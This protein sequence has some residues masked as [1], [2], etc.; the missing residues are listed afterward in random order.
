MG[1]SH[2]ILAGLELDIHHSNE[3]PFV[4]WY[5]AVVYNTLNEALE[6]LR[7]ECAEAGPA[8]CE[9]ISL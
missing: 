4:F 5:G 6:V 3:L 8:V 2:I 7:K 1:A 9:A